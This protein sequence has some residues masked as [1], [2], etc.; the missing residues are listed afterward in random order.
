[1]N[2]KTKKIFLAAVLL[3]AVGCVVM[4]AALLMGGDASLDLTSGTGI[5]GMSNITFE[6]SNRMDN[7]Y[8]SMGEYAVP[9][10]GINGLNI[11]WISGSLTVTPYDGD[12]IAFS[13]Q[14]GNTIDEENALRFGVI[15]NTLYIQYCRSGRYK[16]LPIKEL[17]VQIPQA[18]AE[19][20][21]E[22]ELDST[23]A[24]ITIQGFQARELN[25]DTI[26]GRTDIS[27]CT[28]DEMELGSTSGNIRLEN[29]TARRATIDSI[30]GKVE[31]SG[32][33]GTLEVGTT[34]G[35]IRGIGAVTADELEIS[36]ISGA[37]ELTGSFSDVEQDS[38]SGSIRLTS[39]TP[40]TRLRI[41]SISGAVKLTLPEDSGFTLHFD[42][43][44][45]K[46]DCAFPVIKQKDEYTAGDG[47]ASFSV[48]TTSGGLT[49]QIG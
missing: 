44:S 37:T 6:K 28:A 14:S 40:L 5:I 16:N 3:I 23:S 15:D 46:L 29:V 10:D 25:V 31:L 47:S 43:I 17:E 34:S 35:D 36:T 33:F 2:D 39:D 22:I 38:T 7:A 19:S 30:S 45:G 9:A 49:I 27:N 20:L 21:K 26:S 4:G 24:S 1:M 48:D 41:N 32:G 11:D 18:L 8:D 42:T 12:V 13:E